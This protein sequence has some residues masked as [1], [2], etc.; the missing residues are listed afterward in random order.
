MKKKLIRT[1]TFE[2]NSSSCHTLTMGDLLG[3]N[4]DTSLV[5]DSDGVIKLDVSYWVDNYGQCSTAREKAEYYLLDLMYGVPNSV[6]NHKRGFKETL[7]KEKRWKLLESAI[8]HQTGAKEVI[9][10]TPEEEETIEMNVNLH[11]SNGYD[12]YG[13]IDH[14]SVGTTAEVDDILSVNSFI[15]NDS[16]Y[17]ELDYNG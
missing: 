2:T 15:F 10:F 9:V 17:I 13:G 12:I 3:F 11:S 1:S 4:P 16:S 7:E 14:E 5:P 6:P 8:I